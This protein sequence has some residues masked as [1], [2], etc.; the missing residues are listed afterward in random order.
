MVWIAAK[1][2]VLAAIGVDKVQRRLFAAKHAAHVARRAEYSAVSLHS[3]KRAVRVRAMSVGMDFNYFTS[4]MDLGTPQMGQV[5]SS[6]SSSKG[7]S[8]SYT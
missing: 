4:N 2:V 3:G 7:I 1:V 6:G 8:P 5:Q